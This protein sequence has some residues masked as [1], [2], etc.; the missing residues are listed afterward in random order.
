[1][2]L[3]ALLYENPVNVAQA[4][5]LVDQKYEIKKAKAKFLVQSFADLKQTL[6]QEQWDK[7]KGL[8]SKDLKSA[9]RCPKCVELGTKC[10][11]CKKGSGQ[12]K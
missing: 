12:K 5:A 2:D 7:Y 4:N 9:D 1:V 10:E 8:K 3:T 11:M 6:T